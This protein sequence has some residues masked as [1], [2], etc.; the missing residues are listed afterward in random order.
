MPGER[1]DPIWLYRLVHKDNLEQVLQRGIHAFQHTDFIAPKVRMG[2]I[3]LAEKRDNH[4][5]KMPATGTIGD[6]VAFYFSGHSPMLLKIM[7]GTGVVQHHQRDIVYIL[8]RLQAVIDAGRPYVVTDGHAK[9]ALTDCYTGPEGL[10]R[11]DWD[12]VR[13]Q[14]WKD[15]EE[16]RDRKRRKQA[17]FLVRGHLP[18]EAIGALAVY[19]EDRRREVSDLVTRSGRDIRVKVDTSRKLYY[20]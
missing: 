1:P 16:Y 15:T 4:E 17:E 13:A 3:V 11:I 20:P 10:D 7:T 19:D 9:D 2:D 12:A 8:V 18:A 14:F 5:L 6:H